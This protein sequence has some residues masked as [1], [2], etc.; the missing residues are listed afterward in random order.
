MPSPAEVTAAATARTRKAKVNR[1]RRLL[2][3]PPRRQWQ[4]ISQ[5]RPPLESTRILGCTE[6]CVEFRPIPCRSTTTQH[7]RSTT[8]SLIRWATGCP[9][10]WPL[11][12]AVVPSTWT[13]PSERWRRRVSVKSVKVRACHWRQSAGQ[14]VWLHH[15]SITITPCTRTCNTCNKWVLRSSTVPWQWPMEEGAW[16]MAQEQ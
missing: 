6:R 10:R 12:C 13:A 2:L 1:R 15:R 8:A 14:F 5:C 11:W 16:W 9:Q 7:S 3:H 4:I